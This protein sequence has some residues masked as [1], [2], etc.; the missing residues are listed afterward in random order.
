MH[1]LRIVGV[2]VGFAVLFLCSILVLNTLDRYS[3]STSDTLLDFI[4]TM[5]PI[6]A[7]AIGSAWAWLHPSE[8]PHITE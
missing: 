7:G 4:I 1:T 3:Q 5:A 6:W 2:V 8:Q